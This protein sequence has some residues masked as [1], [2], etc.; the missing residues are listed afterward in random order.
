MYISQSESFEIEFLNRYK[1]VC[2]LPATFS[3][4]EISVI[5]IE[6]QINLQDQDIKIQYRIHT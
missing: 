1:I 2:D 6:L 5:F 3:I 4:Y